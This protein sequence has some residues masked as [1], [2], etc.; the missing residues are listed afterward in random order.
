M[1]RRAWIYFVLVTLLWGV[2]YFFIKIAL[3]D[4]SPPVVVFVRVAIGALVL[5]PAVVTSGGF[6]AVRGRLHWVAGFAL[7]EVCAPFLLISF[8]EQRIT[9]SLTGILIATEPMFLS[10]LALRFDRS[11]RGNPRQVVGMVIGLLGVVVLL[12]LGAQGPNWVA[13]SV[14]ILL[15]TACYACGAL[16]IKN[17]LA[18]ISP[19]VVAA[20]GLS[21]SAV[22]LAV[23]AAG[24]L[25]GALP[26]G[27][28]VFA[29]IVL[30]VACTGAG[31]IA[32]FTLITLAGARRA[33]FITYVSPVVAVFLGV[34]AAGDRFTLTTGV[35]L[36]LIVAGSLFGTTSA[37]RPDGR[38]VAQ[39]VG[40]EG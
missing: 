17:T 23:P 7:F 21:M 28:T 32:F 40:A 13:G 36:V 39:E 19:L 29:L 25:P 15:A 34:V 11:E 12:G 31:F 35:G 24:A 5:I 1:T 20:T 33:T 4:L 26:S 27:S 14:M 6:G 38:L 16:L 18:D 30:G 10:L 3:R 8:G 2:P 22:V 9:S 37:R